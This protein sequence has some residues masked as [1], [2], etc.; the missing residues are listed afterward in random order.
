MV[1]QAQ[2]TSDDL[3]QHRKICTCFATVRVPRLPLFYH[4]RNI[5]WK[6]NHVLC[7]TGC[8]WTVHM[9]IAF[10][11]MKT[12]PSQHFCKVCDIEKNVATSFVEKF[13]LHERQCERT[14]IHNTGKILNRFSAEQKE[15]TK[16]LCFI[17]A[18][19]VDDSS[20]YIEPSPRKCV[21]QWSVKIIIS[22]PNFHNTLQN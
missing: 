21:C 15:N 22:Q 14:H 2:S 11:W 10:F 4:R 5:R 19:D 8:K 16:M 6:I 12:V 17:T 3:P 7:L 20:M 1:W 18:E 9:Q 13:S